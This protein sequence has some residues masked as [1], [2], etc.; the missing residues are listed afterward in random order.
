LRRSSAGSSE[1][2]LSRSGRR[3]CRESRQAREFGWLPG[4]GS[5]LTTDR[6]RSVLGVH[7]QIRGV[8][9]ELGKDTAA[10]AVIR[11]SG[12]FLFRPAFDHTSIEIDLSHLQSQE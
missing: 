12:Y 6:R 10:I 5:T 3:G 2:C 1:A 4:P 9:A 7:G 8:A 11:S